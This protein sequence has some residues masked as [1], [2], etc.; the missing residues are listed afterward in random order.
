MVG[1][2]RGVY[3]LAMTVEP[4]NPYA[5]GRALAQKPGSGHAGRPARWLAIV[6]TL[7][8]LQP[9]AGAGLYVLGR[10]RRILFWSVPSTVAYV[11]MLAG[12]WT[13]K[14]T[15]FAIGV[16]A[17][18]LLIL[19]S[20][21]DTIVVAPAAWTPTFQRALVTL[22]I[23]FAAE[24]AGLHVVKRTVAEAFSIPSGAMMPSLLVGDHIMVKKDT[25]SA[26]RGDMVVFRYPPDP[27]VTFIKRV[28]A[29]AG[30]TIEIRAD[31]V[32]V[33]GAA[34]S[35]SASSEK[36][37]ESGANPADCRLVQESTGLRSYAIMIEGSFDADL[38][39]ITVPPGH[40]FVLG[41]NRHNS[42]DS[43]VW[44]PLPEKDLLGLAMFV[45]WSQ[46]QAGQIRWD[47]FG[48]RL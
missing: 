30:D 11:V 17:M 40:V 42:K 37:P 16:G 2:T 31:A 15:L 28:L 22:L 45:Y 47:R 4:P 9:F 7:L 33:N 8:C 18:G 29:V 36:C 12:V 34:L 20:L 43:R 10:T 21:V 1:F 44:G 24:R 39:P 32:F 25:S 3:I 6:A 26:G 41:D 19:G 46:S 23:V 35:Q 5:P 14:P 27:K 38:S 48:R 13:V